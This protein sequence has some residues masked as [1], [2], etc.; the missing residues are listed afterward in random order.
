MPLTVLSGLPGSGKSSTLIQRVNEQRTK[1]LPAYTFAC[2]DSAAL[3]ARSLLE[4]GR[5]SCRQPG[6]VCKLD[7][8]V[9]VTE[10]S[11][12]LRD[13]APGDLAAFEE[14]QFFG[15][16]IVEE[17]IAAAQRGVE[18]L[19][20]TPSVAQVEMLRQHRVSVTQLR[21]SCRRCHRQDAVT[22]VLLPDDEATES[23]CQDCYSEQVVD[24]RR[25]IV[26]R[27]QDQEPYPGEKTLYQPVDLPETAGWQVIRADSSKRVQLMTAIAREQE[28]LDRTAPKTSYLDLGCNTGYFCE[29]LSRAGSYATGVDAAKSSIQ[30][31]RLL[32]SYAWRGYSRF[33]AEDAYSYLASTR[34]RKFDITSALSVFQWVMIQAGVERG[35]ECLDLLFQKTERICFLE[36]GYTAE[37]HYKDRLKIQI[38]REWTRTAM[39]ERGGFAEVRVLDARTHGI[40]RDLFV[41]LRQAGPRVAPA[42]KHRV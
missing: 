41:G 34:D 19:A 23:L 4:R 27:L 31:A 5:L 9:T 13:C 18:V 1:G 37:A 17:W 39:L 7:Y 28:L 11:N 21:I 30:V 22:F 35:L 2:S 8:F 38:D 25:E 36:M 26:Q 20:C 14:A 10:A 32:N 12:R 6:L 3:R 29:S 42:A 33:H 15:P 16:A 40:K 24:R